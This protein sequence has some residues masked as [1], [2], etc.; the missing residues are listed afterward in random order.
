MSD[1]KYRCLVL[2][3]RKFPAV[4]FVDVAYHG[5][6]VRS[7]PKVYAHPSKVNVEL[8]VPWFDDA[9]ADKTADAK[10]EQWIAMAKDAIAKTD[11]TYSLPDSIE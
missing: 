9:V 1:P 10:C 3:F 2:T 8:S 5:E 4:E 11:I 6:C 7:T